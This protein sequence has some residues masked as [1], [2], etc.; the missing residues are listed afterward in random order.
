MSGHPVIAC[1][2]DTDS[3]GALQLAAALSATLGQPLV[4]ASAYRYE[5]A[6]FAAVAPSAD[7]HNALRFDAAQAAVQRAHGL[8]GEDIDVREEVVP[9]ERIPEALADLARDVEA[10]VL[11]LGRD[12]AGTVTREVIEHAPCPVA[13]SPLTVALPGRP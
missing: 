7:D 6:P 4:V 3:V 10:S 12:L 9:A 5:P 1:F 8:V 2:R 11:V 13:V